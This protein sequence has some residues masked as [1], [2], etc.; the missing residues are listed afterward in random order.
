[1]ATE[2]RTSIVENWLRSVNLVQ[3]TQSFI[4]NGYDDLEVCKQI[5]EDDL[6]AIGVTPPDHRDRLLRAV[7]VLLEEGGAAVY[8]TLEECDTCQ[9]G[10]E[11][12]TVYDEGY[13]PPPG[14]GVSTFGVPARGA[15]GSRLDAYDVGKTAMLSYPRVQLKMLLRDRLV[16]GNIDLACSPYT[17]PVSLLCASLILICVAIDN[18]I[19]FDVRLSSLD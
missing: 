5:G 11:T 13:K 10:D 9:S 19:L 17:A 1:M 4:D 16:D 7:R 18:L 8:F 6:D 14:A 15:S 2:S 12:E 3:Y